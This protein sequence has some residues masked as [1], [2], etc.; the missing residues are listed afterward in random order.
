MRRR[1]NDN[2]RLSQIRALFLR[3][4][5]LNFNK[6]QSDTFRRTRL[7]Q[8]ATAGGKVDDIIG[9]YAEILDGLAAHGRNN[10]FQSI[11]KMFAVNQRQG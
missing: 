11:N 5:K 2:Q 1:G 7:N 6:N 3:L 9:R 8:K 10:G 4:F